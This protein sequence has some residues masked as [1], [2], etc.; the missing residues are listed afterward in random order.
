MLL[1]RNSTTVSLFL[2]RVRTA[3]SYVMLLQTQLLP[4]NTVL[5]SLLGQWRNK[6]RWRPVQVWRP[7]VRNWGIPEANALHWRKYLWHCLDF[8]A[9]PAVIW[10]PG[11]CVPLPPSLRLC[12]GL[13][14]IGLLFTSLFSLMPDGS[15]EEKG[16][17]ENMNQIWK[18]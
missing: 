2:C 7:H 8:S 15:L 10:R 13:Y 9:L 16:S 6:V 14:A 18:T 12:A 1:L 17:S 3:Q 4:L 5:D 11:K